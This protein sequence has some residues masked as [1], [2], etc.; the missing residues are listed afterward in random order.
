MSVSDG[1]FAQEALTRYRQ[2]PKEIERLE[3][4]RDLISK[5]LDGYGIPTGAAVYSPASN[6]VERRQEVAA[7]RRSAILEV[8]KE[9][10]SA[11]TREIFDADPEHF[12]Y[13]HTNSLIYALHALVK[14]GLVYVTTD[15]NNRHAL[16][17]IP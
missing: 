11:S 1:G 13:Q 4:E 6:G 7:E 5:I 16:W 14:Q 15:D 2:I 8:V 3:G 17:S 9:R 10:E 12:G